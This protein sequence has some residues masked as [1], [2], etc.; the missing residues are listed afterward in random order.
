MLRF[1]LVRDVDVTGISGEGVVAD[2][3]EFWDGTVAL[4]WRS[5]GD[6]HAAR[7][8]RPTT[9]L[10]QDIRSV[11]ALHGH[12]G[13]TM[14]RWLDHRV[15]VDG[16]DE[17][18]D[19]R[20]LYQVVVAVPDEQWSVACGLVDW[21]ASEMAAKQDSFLGDASLSIAG[22][23]RQVLFDSDRREDLERLRSFALAFLYRIDRHD[24]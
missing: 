15:V 24:G 21:L 6:E 22:S 12:N 13:A 11:E 19:D 7:G 10:H 3:V 23:M 8:V 20:L 9:V 1:Q 2:G 4:R 14:V 5:V 18:D 16:V 17:V